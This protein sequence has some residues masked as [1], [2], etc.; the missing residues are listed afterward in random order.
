MPLPL[1]TDPPRPQ[2]NSCP[3]FVPWPDGR[4]G[5]CTATYPGQGQYT[6]GTWPTVRPEDACAA[7]PHHPEW[8]EEWRRRNPYHV[9]TS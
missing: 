3:L 5:Y 4:L 2:C 1:E 8:V 7:H 6:Q 9:P